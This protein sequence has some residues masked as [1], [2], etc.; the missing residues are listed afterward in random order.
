MEAR[1]QQRRAALESAEHAVEHRLQLRKA[2]RR[3]IGHRSLEL[4][5]D[6]LIGIQ[7]RGVSRKG[8]HVQ[9]P[10][11]GQE[12]FR[13][14]AFVGGTGIPEQQHRPT[15]VAQGRREEASN[16]AAPRSFSAYQVYPY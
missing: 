8:L 12:L 4:R 16:Q 11:P 1:A 13:D 10:L 14:A 7:F 3:P 5:P 6:L 2:I 15:L 9:A